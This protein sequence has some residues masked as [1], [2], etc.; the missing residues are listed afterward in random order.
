MTQL[1]PVLFIGHGSPMNALEDNRFTRQWREL[2]AA[3]PKPK[4]IVVVSAHWL[5]AGTHVTSNAQP[6]TI[7]DFGG[8]PRALFQV[9]YPARGDPGLARTIGGLLQE[10]SSSSSSSEPLSEDWGLDHGTWSFLKHMRP[11]AD[12]PVLQV[13]IDPRLP[14]ARHLE[15][16]ASLAPLREQGVLLIA[17]GNVTHN[18]RRVDPRAGATDDA[19]VS[20]AARFDGDVAAALIDRDQGFLTRALETADG[21]EAHPSNDHWLPLLYAKGASDDDDDD[22]SFPVRGF[23]LGS[24]SMRAVL[25]Q[26]R[27]TGGASTSTPPSS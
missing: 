13:S 9:Q 10:P 5:T 23:D 2:G 1:M 14:P 8:F 20:W 22:V 6:K 16:G 11:E 17:S 4:A 26:P 12:V 7:H 18:L 21:R 3:L 19:T 15:I 24:F 25:Y 27:P